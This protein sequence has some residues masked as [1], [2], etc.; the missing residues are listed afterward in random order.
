MLPVLLERFK[1]PGQHV[2]KNVGLHNNDALRF[3]YLVFHDLSLAAYPHFYNTL[4]SAVETP[5]WMELRMGTMKD[6]VLPEPLGA[7][8]RTLNFLRSGL[9]VTSRV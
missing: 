1:Y 9:T 6:M 2:L 7:L 5:G 8:M 4:S 3:E